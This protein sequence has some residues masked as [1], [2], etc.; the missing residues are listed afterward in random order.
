MPTPHELSAFLSDLMPRLG[1]I[2]K[3]GYENPGPVEWKERGQPVTAIDRRIE[4]LAREA[5][6]QAWPGHA[7]QGEEHGSTPGNAPTTWYIDPIDGTM[8]FAR[9]LPFF[10]VSIGAWRHDRMIAGSVLDPLRN[11]HF[12]AAA[13]LGAH[14]NERPLQLKPGRVLRDA[15]VSLQTSAGSRYLKTPGFMPALQ[16]RVAKTRRMGSIALE[17]AYVAAGRMDRVVGGS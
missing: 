5:I 3:D 1:A 17:M 15:N 7:I 12:H 4:T 14:L 8:N 16:R 10:S 11:E 9:G 2:A 6:H 13:G